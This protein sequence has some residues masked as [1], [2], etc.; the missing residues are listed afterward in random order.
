MDRVKLIGLKMDVTHALASLAAR[1]N[2]LSYIDMVDYSKTFEMI[3]WTKD[4]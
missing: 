2:Q 3:V 4:T 1:A